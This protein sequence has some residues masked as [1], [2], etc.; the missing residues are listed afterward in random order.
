[1]AIFIILSD[2]CPLFTSWCFI[3]A[4]QPVYILFT[5]LFT[6]L[7]WTGHG[8]IPGNQQMNIKRDKYIKI[9]LVTIIYDSEGKKLDRQYLSYIHEVGRKLLLNNFKLEHS[10][11]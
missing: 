3:N 6:Y 10:F 5:F 1:M 8:K 11:K 2:K 4:A 9:Y 7:L